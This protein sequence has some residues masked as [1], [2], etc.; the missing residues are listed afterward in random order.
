MPYH[1]YYVSIENGLNSRFLQTQKVE[2]Q[3]LYS[4]PFDLKKIDMVSTDSLTRWRNFHVGDYIVS[5]PVRHP[6][7]LLIPNIS[8]D[9]SKRPIIAWDI[10]NQNLQIE[11]GI[12][13][14]KPTTYTYP[15]ENNLL[16]NLPIFKNSLLAVPSEQIWRD[17][18]TLDLRL[19]TMNALGFVGWIKELLVIKYTDLAYKLFILKARQ[20]L[21]PPN[22]INISYDESKQMGVVEVKPAG[23]KLVVDN[24]KV[25][26]TFL[27]REGLMQRLELTTKRY[28]S[29]AQSYRTRFFDSL[30]WEASNPDETIRLYGEFNKLTFDRKIDQEGMTYLFAGWSHVPKEEEF[31][32]TMIQF[33]ERGKKNKVHLDSLYEYGYN[34]FGTSFSGLKESLRETEE[35]KLERKIS[36]EFK[37]ELSDAEKA[38]VVAPDGNFQN[39]EDKVNYFLKKAKEE[40]SKQGST[41]L[42]D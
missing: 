23:D 31:L 37:S 1:F 8:I 35:R 29:I 14:L 18:F 12:K 9:E 15:F 21:F 13:L 6:Y 30:E 33:L 2:A 28:S 10:K 42:V 19:P 38:Q 27:L 4:V 40:G 7:F 32:R 22:A 16:F 17:L 20:L 3:L 34:V 26:Q 36:E 25:E 39:A 41:I 24:Y 5:M 11:I